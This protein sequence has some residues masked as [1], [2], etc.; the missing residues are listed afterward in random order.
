MAGQNLAL[1]AQDSPTSF[2][3]ASA[4]QLSANTDSS[5]GVSGTNS[6]S[7]STDPALLLPSAVLSHQERETPIATN[8]LPFVHSDLGANLESY[9]NITVPVPGGHAV[10]LGQTVLE[11][12]SEGAAVGSQIEGSDPTDLDNAFFLQQDQVSALIRYMQ[13]GPLATTG[14]LDSVDSPA[15]D[16]ASHSRLYADGAGFRESQADRSILERRA[17]LPRQTQSSNVHELGFTWT[18]ILLDKIQLDKAKGPRPD[19]EIPEPI[20][21][22]MQL[23]LCSLSGRPL[24]SAESLAYRDI[25]LRRDTFNYLTRLYFDHFHPVYPFLDRSLLCI[26]VWGWSLCLATAAIGTRYLGLAELTRFGD[27]LCGAIHEL[28]LREVCGFVPLALVPHSNT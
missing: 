18:A 9:A 10:D 11:D 19:L 23:R 21:H 13:N 16:C 25:L 1:D 2:T 8:W 4:K 3:D 28:L 15:H 14:R 7:A 27:D 22:E 20:F 17:A 26:P 12:H 24:L 5:P 6:W